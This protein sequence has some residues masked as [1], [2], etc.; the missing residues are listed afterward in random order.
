MISLFATGAGVTTPASIDGALT[1]TPYP[2][3]NLAVS[4]TINGEAAKITYAGAAPGLVAGVLQVN[5]VLP[6]DTPDVTFNQIVLTVGDFSSPSAVT[7]A[8]Q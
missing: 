7:I 3:P 4:V 6:A 8:A 5:V 1:T 2:A